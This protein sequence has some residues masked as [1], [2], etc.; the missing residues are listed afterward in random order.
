HG[1]SDGRWDAGDY[2]EFIGKRAA[3]QTTYNS[4]YTARGTLILVWGRGR[5]LRAPAVPVAPRTGTSGSGLSVARPAPPFAVREHLEE[6]LD[7]LRIG[8]TSAEEVLD[9]GARVQESE[10]TDFWF[11]KR[12]GPEKDVAELPFDLA[13]SPS[14]PASG[15]SLDPDAGSLR[16]TI[17]LK[18]ITN[19]PK[20]D[21]DHHLKFLL[22]GSDISL[23][24]G[25]RYDAIW[26]GQETH[27]W[28][29]PPL[30]PGILKAG[31]G[32][33]LTIQKVNDLKTTD[34]QSVEYQDAYVNFV[35]LEF[36]ST[37]AVIGD[38]LAFS[39][40]FADSV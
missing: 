11:W 20:A 39:N 28:V 40:T 21:P 5:G 31:K 3:G 12:L 2:I 34:G 38:R 10:L 6:D 19:N 14:A 17:S 26:E 36:P 32:N 9:L 30:N 1:E 25:I 16:I 4:L 15:S 8:S 7:I 33:V 35:R 29:S 37:Y 23:A 27:T 18:G 22:N 13:Y 24:N